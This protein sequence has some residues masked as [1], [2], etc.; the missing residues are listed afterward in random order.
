MRQL[1]LVLLCWGLASCATYTPEAFPDDPAFAPL[2]PE[3]EPQQ[4]REEREPKQALWRL[5]L[6]FDLEPLGPLQVQAQLIQGRL[7]SQLWAE[8]PYTASL[9]ET[10]LDS[11][12]T[13][14]HDCGLNVSGL[15]CHLGKPPQG[16]Q[17]RLEQRW[18]DDT[19]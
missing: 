12:R 6:A 19:A 9:I 18:V 3:P 7:S 16:P 15:D 5:D 10:N 8:R 4:K 1:W 11:L 14:L 2:P 17:T 13:Q